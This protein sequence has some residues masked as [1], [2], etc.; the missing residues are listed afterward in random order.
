MAASICPVSH[1]G[2]IAATSARAASYI[3]AQNIQTAM[4]QHDRFGHGRH[5]ISLGYICGKS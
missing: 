4:T 1:L 5:I 3:V 2:C